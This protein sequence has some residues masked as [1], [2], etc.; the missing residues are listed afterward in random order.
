[1]AGVC[2]QSVGTQLR[3]RCAVSRGQRGG[4]KKEGAQGGREEGRKSASSPTCVMNKSQWRSPGCLVPARTSIA[5]IGTAHPR[6]LRLP[7]KMEPGLEN[8]LSCGPLGS[9]LIRHQLPGAERQ[10][11]D[12]L[13]QGHT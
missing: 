8:F 2:G 11:P 5:F 3:G 1:M 13:K 6:W 9:R 12:V 7:T 4:K 10:T